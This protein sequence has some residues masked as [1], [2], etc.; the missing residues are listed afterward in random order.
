MR[1]GYRQQERHPRSRSAARWALRCHRHS[2]AI[3]ALRGGP[4]S[5][6]APAAVPLWSEGVARRSGTLW[7][8]AVAASH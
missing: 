1:A 6:G 4:R 7:P 2:T 3:P 8:V 5:R